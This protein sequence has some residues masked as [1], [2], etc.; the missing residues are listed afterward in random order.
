MPGRKRS[1]KPARAP[2]RL[3][4]RGDVAAKRFT[5]FKKLNRNPEFLT[6][7]RNNLPQ[8]REIFGPLA[9][10]VCRELNL[11]PENVL[12]REWMFYILMCA[13]SS[14]SIDRLVWL[15]ETGL[16]DLVDTAPIDRG[17]MRLSDLLPEHKKRGGQHKLEP[18]QVMSDIFAACRVKPGTLQRF[19]MQTI[20]EKLQATGK[21]GYQIGI[22]ALV[23]WL[24]QVLQFKVITLPASEALRWVGMEILPGRPPKA[25]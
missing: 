6:A 23:K 14:T 16:I 10:G 19:T 15:K 5:L 17:R 2:K 20:A 12:D 11:N 7:I 9:D 4:K 3:P 25:D 1:R 18:G 21:P 22:E 13:F 24:F 8:L